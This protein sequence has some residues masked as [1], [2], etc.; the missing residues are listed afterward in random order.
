MDL[1]KYYQFAENCISILGVD[2]KVCRGEKAG[3]WNLKRGSANVWIDVWETEQKNYGYFQCMAPVIEVPTKNTEAF[4]R[5]ILEINHNL[6]GVAMTKF[7]SWIYLKTNRELDGLDQN[8]MMAMIN[9]IGVYADQ[10]DDLLRN[11]YWGQSSDAP[12]SV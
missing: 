7:N 1:Q 4:Y 11:K 6:Y 9:R 8:E 2:P 5:E 10:Y 3:Q 12:K